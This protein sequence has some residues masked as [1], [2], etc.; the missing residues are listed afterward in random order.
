MLAAYTDNLYI[1]Y[2][3]KVID[4]PKT[5]ER[6]TIEKINEYAKKYNVHFEAIVTDDIVSSLYLIKYYD[7]IAI[8]QNDTKLFKRIWQIE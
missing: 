8:G 7:I 3:Q 2:S 4:I 6:L 1:S 5:K